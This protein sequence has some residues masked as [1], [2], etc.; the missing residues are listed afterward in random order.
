MIGRE[1]SGEEEEKILVTNDVTYKSQSKKSKKIKTK[2]KDYR[3][4]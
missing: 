4:I 2:N 1:E 3:I